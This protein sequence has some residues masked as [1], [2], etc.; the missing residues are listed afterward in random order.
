MQWSSPITLWLIRINRCQKSLIQ[1]SPPSWMHL[2]ANVWTEIGTTINKY[3]FSFSTA[4]INFR[5]KI[6]G[7]KMASHF[8]WHFNTVSLFYTIH[9]KFVNDA[10]LSV[11]FNKHI[12]SWLRALT[13]FFRLTNF[14]NW[15]WRKVWKWESKQL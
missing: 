12:F 5:F 7:K 11:C 13:E 15:R 2:F 6:R 3:R 10:N 1:S 14:I 8:V 4:S 9:Q